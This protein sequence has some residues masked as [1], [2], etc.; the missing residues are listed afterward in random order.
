MASTAKVNDAV[1]GVS[2][3]TGGVLPRWTRSDADRA[4]ERLASSYNL[5][6]IIVAT[7]AAQVMRPLQLPTVRAFGMGLRP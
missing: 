7:V 3:G 6:A 5:T 2:S 4:L 1:T